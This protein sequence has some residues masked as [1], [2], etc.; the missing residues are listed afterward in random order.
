M[1]PE[2]AAV[3]EEI[4]SRKTNT[5][6][7]S[8]KNVGIGIRNVVTRMYMFYGKDLDITMRT[9]VGEGTAFTFRIPLPGQE[10]EEDT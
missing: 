1:E 9:A 10:G 3:I 2:R 7:K 6:L 4:L 5:T 8:P